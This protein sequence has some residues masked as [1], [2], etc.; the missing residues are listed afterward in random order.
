[1]QITWFGQACFKIQGKNATIV[2]D[3]YDNKYTG[4]K[5]PRLNADIVS[6]SHDHDDHN[7]TKA[8]NGDPFI[9]TNPG[10]YETKNVFIWGIQS[11]HDN[12][13]GAERG[14]NTIFIFQ[15]ED[16]KIAHLGDLGNSLNEQQLEKLESVDILMI[17]VGGV[18][19]ID[20]KKASEVVNQLEP[21]IVIPMHYKIPGLKFKLDP[22]DKFCNEMGIKKNGT[23]DKLKISKKELP[24]D[25]IQI[26]VLKP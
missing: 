6:V 4:L 20:A 3:P 2:T 1:M 11:W 22:V 21:R 14:N 18:Y 17:P 25:K 12:Q 9:I 23:E 24:A 19:T 26:I 13:E 7:N 8:V 16:I 15:I 5:L 10:E